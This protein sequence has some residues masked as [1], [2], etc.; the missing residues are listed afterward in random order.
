MNDIPYTDDAIMPQLISDFDRQPWPGLWDTTRADIFRMASSPCFKCDGQFKGSPR[1][2][3][4]GPPFRPSC[5]SHNPQVVSEVI[6][7]YPEA[8]IPCKSCGMTFNANNYPRTENY[9][10]YGP[11]KCPLTNSVSEIGYQ[12][13]YS[14]MGKVGC[15]QMQE[16]PQAGYRLPVENMSSGTLSNNMIIFMVFILSILMGLLIGAFYVSLKTAGKPLSAPNKGTPLT[17]PE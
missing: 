12:P 11:C 6:A 5:A 2:Q 3:Q 15:R 8:N 10:T 4:F 16:G 1:E 17:N 14:C 13:W 9:T 7:R